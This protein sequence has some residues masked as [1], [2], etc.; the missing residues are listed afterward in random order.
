MKAR[1]FLEQMATLLK[2]RELDARIEQGA[3]KLRYVSGAGDVLDAVTKRQQIVNKIL[4]GKIP[5]MWTRLFIILG[6]VSA[7]AYVLHYTTKVLTQTTTITP[8][9]SWNTFS[10]ALACGDLICTLLVAYYAFRYN[11]GAPG[12]VRI[13]QTTLGNVVNVVWLIRS[14]HK[15]IERTFFENVNSCVG[16]LSGIMAFFV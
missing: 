11:S 2:L 16:L 7:I 1:L 9:R 3:E 12:N 13:T 5:T 8:L 15:G 14:Y 10:L 6:V 4:Y